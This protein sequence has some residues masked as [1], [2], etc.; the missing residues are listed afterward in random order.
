MNSLGSRRLFSPT[1][2][3]QDPPENEFPNQ[4]PAYRH[5]PHCVLAD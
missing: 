1:F 2:S 3:P 4:V 5:D